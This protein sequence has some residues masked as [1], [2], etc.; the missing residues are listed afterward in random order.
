M[1]EGWKKTCLIT[2]NIC[3]FNVSML[4]HS[5]VFSHLNKSVGANTV[6]SSYRLDPIIIN[7]PT[8]GAKQTSVTFARNSEV[9][10]NLLR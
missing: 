4:S 8:S 9:R 7:N 5:G 2:E 3:Y 1:L 10:Y 6:S